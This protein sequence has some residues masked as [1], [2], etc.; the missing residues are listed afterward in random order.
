[1]MKFLTF[2]MIISLLLLS[3]CTTVAENKGDKLIIRGWGKAK[4][5]DGSEIEGKPLIEFPPLKFEN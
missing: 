2:V 3:S 5:T 4:F 1:M